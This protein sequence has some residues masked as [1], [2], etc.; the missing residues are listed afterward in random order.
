M[1][2]TTGKEYS[3]DEILQLLLQ[4]IFNRYAQV[5]PETS[6]RIENEYQKALYRLNEWHNYLVKGSLVNAKITG[7]NEYGQLL[8]ETETEKILVCDL[9]EVKFLI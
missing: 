5:N 4:S 2:I 9:K 3:L 6:K 7:T 1:K 8:L